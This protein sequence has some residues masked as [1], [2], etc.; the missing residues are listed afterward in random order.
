V[1]AGE[2]GFEPSMRIE[3]YMVMERM[4]EREIARRHKY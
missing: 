1:L 2:E 3:K 4:V